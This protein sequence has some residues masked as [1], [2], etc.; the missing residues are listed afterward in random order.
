MKQAE[1]FDYTND[2]LDKLCKSKG[3][4]TDYQLA[5]FLG[6]SF[7]TISNYR[8]HKTKMDPTTC[9]QVAE[10]LRLDPLLVIARMKLEAA[11]TDREVNVWKRYAGRLVLAAV[12]STPVIF[13]TEVAFAQNEATASGHSIHYTHK[14]AQILRRAASTL[15]RFFRS[16]CCPTA[17]FRAAI[18]TRTTILT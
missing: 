15:A 8:R 3:L 18:C 10:A 1:V 5:K 2:L 9:V 14:F 13:G 12:L 17:I 11:N 4:E 6:C 7:S 16:M